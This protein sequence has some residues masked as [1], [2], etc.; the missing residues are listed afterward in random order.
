MIQI[1]ST[2]TNILDKKP[3]I[4]IRMYENVVKTSCCSSDQSN[5]TTFFGSLIISEDGIVEGCYVKDENILAVQWHPER[6]LN[7]N[8][9]NNQMPI[10]FL[11]NGPWWLCKDEK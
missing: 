6:K 4:C 11:K 2:S 8:Y 9:Y 3:A 7:D 5:T 10:D 1:N